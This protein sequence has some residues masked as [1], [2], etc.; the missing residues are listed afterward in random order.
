[1]AHALD[2]G[3]AK[4]GMEP[5][6]CRKN[7]PGGY[8]AW[9]QNYRLG[10][11]R[12]VQTPPDRNNGQRLRPDGSRTASFGGGTGCQSRILTSNLA[13]SSQHRHN[14]LP[15]AQSRSGP[16]RRRPMAVSPRGAHTR[17]G[18]PSNQATEPSPN[19]ALS[20]NGMRNRTG[21]RNSPATQ[22]SRGMWPRQSPGLFRFA[23]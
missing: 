6:Q 21:T 18:P 15:G 20:R 9:W 19:G 11:G 16:Q 12:T 1:M 8:E 4:H 23:H 7:Q 17:K 22:T 13:G 5:R 14:S 2:C 10:A 3:S